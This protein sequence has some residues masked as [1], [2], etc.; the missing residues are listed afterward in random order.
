ML[1]YT[2]II[3]P[4]SGRAGLPR[5]IRATSSMLDL[6]GLVIITQ[7]QPIAVQFSLPSSRLWG[8]R[9]VGRVR[10]TSMFSANM[11]Q[12]NR[13]RHAQGHRH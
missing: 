10:L 5:S 9:G 12:R 8:Q 7:L 13:Q 11:A 2:K 1:G 3:A 4:L 6:T